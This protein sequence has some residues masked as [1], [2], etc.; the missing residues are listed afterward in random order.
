MYVR[1]PQ[2]PHYL[3]HRSVHHL[4]IWSVEARMLRSRHPL[5]HE[6]LE[7]THGHADFGRIADGFEVLDGGLRHRLHVADEQSFEKRICTP[8]RMLRG[9]SSHAAGGKYQLR[10]QGL[11]DP[12]CTVLVE[13]RDAV[14]RQDKVRTRSGGGDVHK[15]EDGLLRDSLIP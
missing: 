4:R 3:Q 6:G 10:V 7:L 12:G 5:L 8:F 15:I 13:S 11:L 1:Y 9:K 2:I 14:L